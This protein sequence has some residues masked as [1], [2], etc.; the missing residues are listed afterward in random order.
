MSARATCPECGWSRLYKRPTLAHRY[1]TQHECD[2]RAA[3]ATSVVD[4]V[5]QAHQVN[6][7]GDQAH[8]IAV[9]ETEA[10]AEAPVSEPV[11]V[12]SAGEDL[13]YG[14]LARQLDITAIYGPAAD[15][16]AYAGVGLRKA[17]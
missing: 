6:R 10:A 13:E 9:G 5:D 17:G 3:Q 12:F 8:S 14:E 2:P 1:G 4:H 16:S 7:D 15:P 11:V